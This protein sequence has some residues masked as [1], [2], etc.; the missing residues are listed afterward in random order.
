MCSA[1]DIKKEQ[2]NLPEGEQGGKNHA[3][4]MKFALGLHG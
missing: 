4:A 3:K 1:L 2:F